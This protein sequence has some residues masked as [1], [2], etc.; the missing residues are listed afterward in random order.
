MSNS[1]YV[2]TARIKVAIRDGVPLDRALSEVRRQINEMGQDPWPAGQDD[3]D[4][5]V[6]VGTEAVAASYEN[7][8]T[9]LAAGRGH[10]AGPQSSMV[11]TETAGEPAS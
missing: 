2:V 1:T 11:A 6:G 3:A 5:W 4:W 8:G 10:V 9:S 7:V